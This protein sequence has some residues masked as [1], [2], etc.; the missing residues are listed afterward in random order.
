MCGW[1]RR[2]AISISRRK[3]SGPSA[4]GELGVQ[5]LERHP[6]LVPEIVGEIDRG[7]AAAPE[8]ALDR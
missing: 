3:R 2:A 5:D 1:L 8:L 6:A 4:Y 7:H